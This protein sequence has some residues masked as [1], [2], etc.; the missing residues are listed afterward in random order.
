M[1]AHGPHVRYRMCR[2]F[3]SYLRSRRDRDFRMADRPG[4]FQDLLRSLG[5]LFHD[6][7]DVTKIL[8]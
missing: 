4:P 7:A 8:V 6:I 2:S 3:W 5:F 1:S